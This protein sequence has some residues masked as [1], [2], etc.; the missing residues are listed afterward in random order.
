MHKAPK[1]CAVEWSECVDY[2]SLWCCRRFSKVWQV[3]SFYGSIDQVGK[4]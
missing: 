2:V 4:F 3:I 1:H